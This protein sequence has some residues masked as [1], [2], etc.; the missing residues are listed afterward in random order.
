MNIDLAP[1]EPEQEDAVPNPPAVRNIKKS[2]AIVLISLLAIAAAVAY[3]LHSRGFEST[4]NAFVDSRIVQVSPR[5][6]G[7][8]LRV[9]VADNQ[10]VNRGD[11]LAELD[12]ADY[13]ARLAQ[14][15]ARL[16]DADAAA[17]GAAVNVGLTSTVSGAVLAQ[18]TAALAGARGQL[19]VLRARLAQDEAATKAAAAGLEQAQARQAAA[20][21]EAERA[22]ADAARYHALYQKDEVSKQMLDRATTDAR[23]SAANRTAAAQAVAAARAQLAQA[24]AGRESTLAT[25]RQAGTQVSQAEARRREAQSAP[26]QV[27]LRQ[28][29]FASSRA[30]HAEAQAALEQARLDLSYTKIYAP[31]AGFITRKS[32]EPGN[33]VGAGQV[34]LA[35]VSGRF[36]VVANFKETQLAYMRPGQ[37]VEVK[38]DAYPGV[39]LRGRVESIQSGTGARFSLLPAENAT[40]NYVKVVQRVPV[41]IVLLDAPPAHLR[42]GPGMSVEPE[43]KVQ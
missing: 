11:L 28:T 18:S 24:Q 19:D 39:K 38:I 15:Q 34:L 17:D 23:A 26:Q 42:V 22:A 32:I 35:L 29:G 4:D 30:R 14:A 8:V 25:L 36:W 31:E 1:N 13:K 33:F 27:H 37:S 43:V 41:K 16:S 2:A 7:Q 6:S 20:A 40:G 3:Y 21:A 5:V 9:L 12:P 10:H